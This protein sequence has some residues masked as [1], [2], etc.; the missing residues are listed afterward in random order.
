MVRKIFKKKGGGKGKSFYRYDMS[1][2]NTQILS[3]SSKPQLIFVSEIGSEI[4]EREK[5]IAFTNMT[6]I[7]CQS[8]N[9]IIQGKSNVIH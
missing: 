5:F 6:D 7:K 2:N 4:R 8:L 1:N 3:Q 9:T